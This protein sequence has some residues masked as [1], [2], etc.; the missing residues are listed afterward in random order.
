MLC[1][2]CVRGWDHT[3]HPKVTLIH[4]NSPYIACR[5]TNSHAAFHTPP[6]TLLARRLKSVA[7]RLTVA[8]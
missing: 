8:E 7:G 3:W 6:T 2:L 5:I 1:V 4:P